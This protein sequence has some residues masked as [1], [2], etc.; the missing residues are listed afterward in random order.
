MK[1]EGKKFEEDFKN[2]I[3]QDVLFIRLK[4]AGGWSNGDNTRFT[5]RNECDGIVFKSPL[6]YLTELKSHKGKSIPIKDVVR[7]S[8]QKAK[9]EKGKKTRIEILCE[10][11]RKPNVIAGVAFNF[12]DTE[13]TYFVFV[14]KVQQF[15]DKGERASFPLVWIKENGIRIQQRKKVTRYRYDI[16]TFFSEVESKIVYMKARIKR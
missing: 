4:D 14:D 5:I 6:I 15:I 8:E 13:E 10:Y 12:R 7:E 3:P 9:I 16:N 2:S 11:H 1:G